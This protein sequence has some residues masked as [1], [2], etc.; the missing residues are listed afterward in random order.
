MVEDNPRRP[1][2]FI[3]GAPKCGTTS[4]VEY[5]RQHPDVFMPPKELHFFGSDI[6][7]NPKGL[8]TQ[9]D[10]LNHFSKARDEKMTGEKSVWY[11]YSKK[12]ASEIKKFSPH[13]KII[14]H[15]RNPVDML[16]S[17]HG[18]NLRSDRENIINFEKALEAEEDRR[19]GLRIPKR[20]VDFPQHLFYSEIPLYTEQIKRYVEA[21]GW[22]QLHI[23]VFDDL[24]NNTLKV[25]RDV[26]RFLEVDDQFTPDLKVHNPGRQVKSPIVR[27][28]IMNSWIRTVARKF[29]PITTR[30]R[31]GQTLYHWNISNKPK[32]P[33]NKHI[34]KR[35]QKQFAPEVK[36]LS[37]LLDRDLTHW[38]K[39]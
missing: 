6:N 22:K 2:F 26:L 19:K 7:H 25:Y 10:Y 34:R 23:I 32:P 3:V 8:V 31:M 37:K 1:N 27:D 38:C 18:H 12:A 36:R 9:E 4:M 11:L 30:R 14:I 17:L 21:F 5:L 15:I 35:L 29:L 28:L 39:D 20:T 24:V 33:M 13:A 16:Y